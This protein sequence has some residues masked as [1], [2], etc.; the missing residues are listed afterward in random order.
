[1]EIDLGKRLGLIEIH[2]DSISGFSNSH[3][4]LLFILDLTNTQTPP[5]TDATRSF[6]YS[7]KLDRE[8]AESGIDGF[9]HVSVKQTMSTLLILVT[10][11]NSSIFPFNDR[12]LAMRIFGNRKL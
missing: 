1:M 6:L 7:T 3:I 10:A 12:T 11:Y 5:P 8:T 4:R 9:N 2:K